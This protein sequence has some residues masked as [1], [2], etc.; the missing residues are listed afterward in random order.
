[1]SKNI[2]ISDVD[3][4]LTDGRYIYLLMAKLQKCLGRMIMTV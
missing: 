4:C 3:G 2:V 1:M